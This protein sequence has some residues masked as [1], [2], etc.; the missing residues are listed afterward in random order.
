MLGFEAPRAR[1]ART[2]RTTVMDTLCP[3]F[4]TCSDCSNKR[5]RLLPTENPDDDVLSEGK[6]ALTHYPVIWGTD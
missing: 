4:R 6:A 1:T 2:A 3:C 5:R